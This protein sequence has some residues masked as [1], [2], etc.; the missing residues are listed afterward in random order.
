M[1]SLEQLM[2]AIANDQRT[3]VDTLT[4]ILPILSEVFEKEK[5]ERQQLKVNNTNIYK[6]MSTK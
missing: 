1:F 3:P 6:I 2:F 5:K 4:Q